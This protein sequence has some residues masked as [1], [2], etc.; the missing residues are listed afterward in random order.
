MPTRPDATTAAG[1]AKLT[2][3]ETVI[4]LAAGGR[5]N[6]P[7]VRAVAD[8]LAGAGIATHAMTH[9]ELARQGRA[10]SSLLITREDPRLAVA[11]AAR[12]DAPLLHLDA[13]TSPEELIEAFDRLRVSFET[14]L[15]IRLDRRP[16][17]DAL[18]E[19]VLRPVDDNTTLGVTIDRGRISLTSVALHTTTTDPLGLLGT[20]YCRHNGPSTMVGLC[21]QS[22]QPIAD[23]MIHARSAITVRPSHHG[24]EILVRCDGHSFQGLARHVRIGPNRHY[25]WVRLPAA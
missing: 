14:L 13:T 15:T 25:R 18:A 20:A 21:W 8:K 9:S 19:C 1:S 23:R 7:W 2:A 6:A 16:A 3:P 10:R 12:L 24:A 17:R 4:V 5:R 22:N 11:L